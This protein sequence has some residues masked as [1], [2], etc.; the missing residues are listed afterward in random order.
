MATTTSSTT[1][2]GSTILSSLNSGGI[3]WSTLATNLSVAQFATQNDRL[4]TR[5]DTLDAQ[6]STAS[7]LKS[8]LLTLTTSI[9]TAVRSGDL[10]PQPSM[11]NSAVATPTLSGSATPKGSYSI[12]V[13]QLAKAQTLASP[14]V[15]S[16]TTTVGSGTLT[17][18]F[19]SMAQTS[20][21][22]ANGVTTTTTGFTEDTAHT[23]AAITIPAGATLSDVASAINAAKAGV[24]AYVANTTDGPRLVM[25]GA[26]GAANGFILE[27]SE[28][29]AD[30]GLSQL[31][32]NPSTGAS[33]QLLQTSQDAAWKLDGLPMSSAT[34]TITEAIPGVN[35]KLT[36]TN[37]G[38]PATLSFAD[39]TASISSTMTDLVDA[40]NEM[41]SQVKTATDPM[42]GDLARD[43]GA[44]ALKRALSA[45][46]GTV[47]MPNAAAGEPRT[48]SDLGVSIQRDGTFALDGAMLAKALADNPTAVAAMFT[49][50]LYGVYG[51]VDGLNRQMAASGNA[52]SLANSITR[53]TAQK[54]QVTT[55]L[56]DLSTKQE[57]LRVQ[58]VSRFAATQTNISAS[59]STLTFLKNQIDAWN[60][61]DN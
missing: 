32:W 17:L 30:P 49:N 5:S 25:K 60:S 36:A 38:S 6:I 41:V 8:T 10:S 28:N 53:L 27:A 9:A 54:T 34:N 3:D 24:T 50:G 20:T 26:E 46:S 16:T 22:D 43:G 52:Y 56:S 7:S 51:T 44:L 37:A 2:A 57:A 48:L 11:S 23:A 12:E 18:R 19:G 39:N 4:T 14:T 35:L 29:S 31:A 15:A 21:T 13:T 59:T 61:S 47:I 40:L 33:N 58:L 1:S 45:L 42:T 55:D